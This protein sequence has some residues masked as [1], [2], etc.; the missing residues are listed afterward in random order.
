M[1]KIFVHIPKTA[2][3]FINGSLIASGQ[4]TLVHCESCIDS[5]NFHSIIQDY[6]W[7]SGHVAMA[8]FKE[9]IS[10]LNIEVEYYSLLR[11]PLKQLVSQICWQIEICSKTDD[12]HRFLKGHPPDSIHRILQALFCDFNDMSSINNLLSRNPG[13]LTNNQTITLMAEYG[14]NLNYQSMSKVDCLEYL[15]KFR[16]QCFDMFRSFKF[17]GSDQ[18]INNALTNFGVTDLSKTRNVDKNKSQLYINP[19]LIRRPEFV[20]GLI[21]HNLLDCILY[22]SY[23]ESISENKHKLINMDSFDRICDSIFEYIFP[24]FIYDSNS[25]N[26]NKIL[27]IQMSIAQCLKGEALINRKKYFH[28]LGLLKNI[29]Y[30]LM[31]T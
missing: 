26:P 25:Y 12:N 9:I 1:K 29:R 22:L 2:G 19:E 7:I 5:S 20:K 16:Y 18:N 17:L 27:D 28:I 8:K 21:I 3:T 6:E 14:I 4:P 23:V 13:Y 30:R 10:K 11:H 31:K 15:R 24:S